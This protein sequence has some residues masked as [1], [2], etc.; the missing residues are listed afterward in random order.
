MFVK[1]VFQLVMPFLANLHLS[2]SKI[3]SYMYSMTPKKC[4]FF[5][6]IWVSKVLRILSWFQIRGH[7]WKKVYTEKVIC[8]KLL[9]VSSIEEGTLQFC[10]LF[11]LITF[12]VCKFFAFFSTVLKSA[13]I[14][15]CFDT[16]IQIFL[17][18]SV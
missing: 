11:L 6:Y 16:K 3:Y 8:K 5:F 13:I 2:R 18:K 4:Y 10:T 17:R 7:N 15:S 9:Q 14:L 12:F 1:Q